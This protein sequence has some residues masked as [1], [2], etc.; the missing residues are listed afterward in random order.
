MD[1]A[2]TLRMENLDCDGECFNDANGDG[3]CDEDESTDVRT[4]PLD[5]LGGYNA[6]QLRPIGNVMLR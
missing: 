3:V 4:E 5:A 1:H 6:M 2:P